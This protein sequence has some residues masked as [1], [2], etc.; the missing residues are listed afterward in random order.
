MN[1]LPLHDYLLLAEDA[2]GIPAETI[3]RSADLG[4]AES[5]L[6]APLASFEGQD[7]YPEPHEKVAVLL[8]RLVR[9]HPLP[10]GNKRAALLAAIEFT[11]RNG[12]EWH[13]PPGGQDEVATV[14]RAVA[15]RELSEAALVQWVA[16]RLR[17][18]T[19]TEHAA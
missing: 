5:A 2:L 16:E 14:V 18:P 19:R 1:E 3:R 4:L 9:N 12:M 7:F 13:Q 10:D 11:R 15:A 6:L 8:S 17:G